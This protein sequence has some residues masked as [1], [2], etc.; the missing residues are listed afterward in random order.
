[1]LLV[2]MLACDVLAAVTEMEANVDP[3]N[4][5]PTSNT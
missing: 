5:I 3:V 4:L 2:T 1:M